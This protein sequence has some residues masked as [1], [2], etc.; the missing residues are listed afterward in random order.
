MKKLLIAVLT[1]T[2]L[3]SC[4]ST[5]SLETMSER[6]EAASSADFEWDA[7]GVPAVDGTMASTVAYGKA[8]QAS[9]IENQAALD[10]PVIEKFDAAVKAELDAV[11]VEGEEPTEDQMKAAVVAVRGQMT[12]EERDAMDAQVNEYGIFLEAITRELA[13]AG[14][15]AVA[16]EAVK[17]VLTDSNNVSAAK[18]LGGLQ[19][20]QAAAQMNGALGMVSTIMDMEGIRTYQE[21]T[22]RLWQAA[23]RSG[24]F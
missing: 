7:I 13:A 1:A 24:D 18:A 2:S 6:F 5:G 23:A 16:M 17:E 14:V 3:A 12:S 15:K 9:M 19:G 4:N 11:V 22:K 8:L 21:R 20:L 10:F